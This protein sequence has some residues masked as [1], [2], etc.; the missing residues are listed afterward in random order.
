[1]DR[2]IK[3]AIGVFFIGFFTFGIANLVF[4]Y[5]FSD[6][7][8]TNADGKIINPMKETVLNII[9]FGLYGAF[10]SFKMGQKL[11]MLEG[12]EN[13]EDYN[14]SIPD[15]S[16]YY[17]ET[18]SDEDR[19][20]IRDILNRSFSYV[21]TGDY[22]ASKNEITIYL[23]TICNLKKGDQTLIEMCLTD[24][25]VHNLFLAFYHDYNTLA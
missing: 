8:L 23:K 1:M 24:T 3:K 21:V 6:E 14:E 9:T 22:N 17:K 4:L 19:K 15:L 25:L 5:R 12:R 11:D 7:M 13:R 10:W 16:K 18:E 2:D 20:I